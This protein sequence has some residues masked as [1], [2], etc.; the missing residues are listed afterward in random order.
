MPHRSFVYSP[1]PG[2]VV[3]GVGSFGKLA[4]EF[5]ELKVSRALVVCTPE[6]SP[7]ADM[8][9]IRLGAQCVGIFPKAVMHVPIEIARQARSY[10]RQTG[11]DCVVAIGGGSTIGLG[12]AIA[13]ESSIPILAIRNHRVRREENRPRSE[14]FATNGHLRSI[15]DKV[16]SCRNERDEWDQRDRTLR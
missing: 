16:A 5:D 15:V 13:L 11:A 4:D 8:V 3:F 12:K 2:R 7:L 1:L 10:A 6:Q 14:G 9:A